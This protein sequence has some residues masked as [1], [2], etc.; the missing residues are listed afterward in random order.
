[1]KVDGSYTFAAPRQKVWDLLQDPEVLV[2]CIPGCKSFEPS[3]DDA[4]EVELRMGVGPVV[5]SY[6]ASVEIGDKSPP[7]SY[8]LTVRG[9]GAMGTA[10]GE[11]LLSFVEEGDGTTV[12]IEA[13]AHVT[14]VV[15]RVGQRMMGSASKML[16]KQ[17][18]DCIASRIGS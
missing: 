12:E 4:Y 17:F 5:G 2:G 3:G 1:M 9:G 15:A 13:E 6:K 14:G 10:R 18:F 7:D 11:A 8:R 16:M